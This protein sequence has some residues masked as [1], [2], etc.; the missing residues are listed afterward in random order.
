MLITDL[1]FAL[2][3]ALLFTAVFSGL[4][5]VRGPWASIP[6]FFIIVF[7]ST[8]AIGAYIS[9]F[10]PGLWG[11]FWLPF[12]LS[13]LVVS[14]LLAAAVV[15]VPKRETTVELIDLKARAKDQKRALTTLGVFF[16]I[17]VV[18]LIIMI[19]MRYL[20]NPR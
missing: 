11:G 16:W 14:L 3:F 5:Q 20:N 15:S 13:G 17:L 4:F 18:A 2:F 6:L 7:L 10:G 9:P 8:W 12:F 19:V 1:L